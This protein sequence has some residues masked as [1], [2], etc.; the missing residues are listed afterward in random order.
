M[1][2][3]QDLEKSIFYTIGDAEIARNETKYYFDGDYLAEVIDV[4]L[5]DSTHPNTIGQK[6]IFIETNVLE[7][8]VD[9]G[10]WTNGRGEQ[11]SSTQAGETATICIK[12]AWSKWDK[13]MKAFLCAAGKIT[14]AQANEISAAKWIE[15]TEKAC[16][17]LGDT[18]EAFD[19]SEW[20]EQPLK[21]AQL[22]ITAT[23]IK[24]NSGHDFT[25][26]GYAATE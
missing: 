17:H 18:S 20:T 12:L 13:Y 15:F 11:V 10:T 3:N 22:K 7:V 21:G 26:I 25:K 2:R 19:V 24:T 14:H 1:N 8:L 23:T 9:K 6:M 4:K 16:F 5:V